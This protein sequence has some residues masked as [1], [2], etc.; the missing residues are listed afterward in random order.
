MRVYELER[1][2][3]KVEFNARFSMTQAAC[4]R[5]SSTQALR[6]RGAAAHQGAKPTL[7]KP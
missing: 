5:A 7:H 4:S 2:E 6:T 3:Q 1:D